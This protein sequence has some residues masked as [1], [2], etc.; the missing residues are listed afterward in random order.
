MTKSFLQP[1]DRVAIALVLLLSLLIGLLLSQGDAVT[2]R[3]RNFS[4]QGKQVGADDTA[5]SLTFSRPMNAKSV[6]ENIKIEPPLPGKFSWAGRRMVY[7][8]VAPAPYGMNYKMQLQNARDKFAP[9]GKKKKVMQPYMGNFRS[10]DRILAYIGVE[11]DEQG[12]LITYNFNSGQKKILTPKDLVV[13]DFEPY[14]NGERILFS[15]T[16]H[17]GSQPP[18]ITTSQLYSVTTGIPS[19][20]EKEA[21]PAGKVD[22]LLDSKDYQNLKFDLSADGKT[23]AVQRV[24]KDN[25]ADFGLWFFNSFKDSSQEKPKLQRLQTQPSGDFLITPDSQAVAAAQGQGVAILPLQQGKSK[26]LD[27]LPQYG[28]VQAFSKDGAQAVMVKFNTNYTRNLFLVTNQGAQKELLNTTGS[29]LNCQFDP[30]SPTLYCLLTQLLEG[31]QYQEQPYI[32]AINLKTGEQKPLVLLPM[33]RDINMS[34]SPDGLA[35]LFD[36]IQTGANPQTSA[37][38]PLR[39][40]DGQDIVSSRLWL[41]PLFPAAMQQ[42]TPVQL[43]PEELPLGGV[44]PRWLP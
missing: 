12:K 41:L 23:I 13:I 4:W 25:P 22:L 21:E 31:E 1:L 42:G 28:M 18:D 34:L 32:A 9:E 38:S 29:I 19:Q 14:P 7:T 20:P 5:F 24:K 36:Q 8:L 37:P 33:G 43:K 16:Q 30:A 35:L 3:V 6:E 10:R 39:T 17:A 26:P 44:Q 2:A 15:A 40:D 27:F 11:G